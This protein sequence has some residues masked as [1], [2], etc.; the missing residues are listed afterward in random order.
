MSTFEDKYPYLTY[1]DERDTAYEDSPIGTDSIAD[2]AVTTSKIANG[3]VTG[4]KLAD[5]AIPTASADTLGGVKV[6]EGLSIDS[7]GVLSADTNQMVVHIDGGGYTLRETYQEIKNFI[8]NNGYN[9]VAVLDS[10][11]CGYEAT[12]Y[13][14][15]QAPIT[16]Y[17][18]SIEFARCYVYTANNNKYI[19]VDTLKITPDNTVTIVYGNSISG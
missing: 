1:S 18:E 5:G 6:G 2:G 14:L 17:H 10:S 4:D 3:A 13:Q 9:V 16:T 8:D 7:D 15:I 19:G 12:L 11:G